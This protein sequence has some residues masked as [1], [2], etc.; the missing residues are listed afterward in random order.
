L[1][2]DDSIRVCD[3]CRKDIKAIGNS[4]CRKCG[5]FLPDGGE[6]CYFCLQKPKYY[7]EFI[8]SYGKY[9]G[10]LRKLIHKFKY[11]NRDY[12]SRFLSGLMVGIINSHNELI[13]ADCIIP[14]PMHW[15]KKLAR[16]Y[17]QTE[18]L[19]EH[20]AQHFDKPLLLNTL[21]R[22]KLGLSQVKLQRLKRIENVKGCFKVNRPENIKGKD[23]LLIDD[24]STTSSTLNE[25][26]KVLS[27]AGA[28]KVY[29]LTIAKD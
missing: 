2:V 17:N 16:G 24:V 7:F 12:L 8:R 26:A 22:K 3:V 13:M 5:S 10:V 27:K 15:F 21:K 25:C 29:C 11:N 28:A 14:V 23:I 18:L 4:Y 20:I 9:E 1:P 6:N 19:A